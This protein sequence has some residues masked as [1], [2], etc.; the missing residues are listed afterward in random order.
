[1]DLLRTFLVSF[2]RRITK[3][4]NDPRQSTDSSFSHNVR[5][6]LHPRYITLYLACFSLTYSPSCRPATVKRGLLARS[7]INTVMDDEDYT[8]G[9]DSIIVSTEPNGDHAPDT[10]VPSVIFGNVKGPPLSKQEQLPFHSPSKAPSLLHP[11]SHQ[12]NPASHRRTNSPS[13]RSE[14]MSTSK[15]TPPRH[16]SPQVRIP[17]KS[18]SS[19]V[20]ATSK[21]GLVYDPRM[22]F[23]AELPD[24]NINP[25]DI[26]PEDPRRIHSI[27]EELR[28]AGLVASSTSDGDQEDHCWRIAARFAT[29][30]EI[31]LI[32]TE[33]H[34]NLVRSFQGKFAWLRL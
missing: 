7:T 16:T 6:N 30:P 13:S 33:D 21:T 1:M 4:D 32:H 19:L 25:D 22:R 28:Q 20:Y 5:H 2:V 24:M 3:P 14:K 23:H 9:E 12:S 8:M 27:F 15:P 31:L 18:R 34:Y 11:N 17:P 29:R 10:V 26:H